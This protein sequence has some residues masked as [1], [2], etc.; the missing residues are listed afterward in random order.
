MSLEVS[1]DL[2]R[3]AFLALLDQTHQEITRYRD[4]EW[5]VTTWTVALIAGAYAAERVTPQGGC[6]GCLSRFL[7]SAFTVLVGSYGCWH[8]YFLHRELTGQRRLRRK[9]EMFGEFYTVDSYIE[10][11]SLLHK[12]LFGQE[13]LFT[14]GLPHLISWWGLIVLMISFANLSI[15]AF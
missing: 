7:L 13:V 8:L 5:K 10:G 9:L 2:K 6:L 14:Q 12:R 3:P 4:M 11:E 1:E 15:W